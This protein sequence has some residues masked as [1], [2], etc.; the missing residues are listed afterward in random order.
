[1]TDKTAQTKPKASGYEA[2][3]LQLLTYGECAATLRLSVDALRSMVA[4]GEVPADAIVKLG[5][6]VRFKAPAIAAWIDSLS[7]RK[8]DSVR[9]GMTQVGPYAMT[10]RDVAEQ[11]GYQA[12]DKGDDV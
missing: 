2:R 7:S 9:A 1:M 6:R 5:T 10:A 3:P 11:V 4:R 12:G 8:S